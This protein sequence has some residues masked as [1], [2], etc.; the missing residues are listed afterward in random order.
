LY[1]NNVIQVNSADGNLIGEAGEGI[2]TI[3]NNILL[4]NQ[5]SEAIVLEYEKELTIKNNIISGFLWR[6]IRDK[7]PHNDTTIIH[8]NLFLGVN[9]QTSVLMYQGKTVSFKNNVI[10]YNGV[11]VSAIWDTLETDYN[12]YWQ[13]TMDVKDRAKKGPHD[14]NVD[15][16]FVKD[17]PPHLDSTYDFHLQAFSPGI[18]A[19]DPNILDVDGSRSDIGLF[20]GPGGESYTYQDLAPRDPRNLSAVVDSNY[21]TLR[22]NRNTEAD[23]S[24]YKVYRDTVISFQIDTTKL[25]SSQTDTFFVQINPHNV[26]KY[27]YKITCV[28]N[29]GNESPPSTELV[30]NITSVS[31]EDYPMTINDYVLYQN[32]PNPFNPSTKIGYKLKERGYVKVMVYDVKGELVSVLVNKEQNAGYYE[33][34]FSVGSP[35]SSVGNSIASGIYLYRIEVIGEGRIPVFSDMKKMMLVK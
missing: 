22:W 23:T 12:I 28:D 32:Y 5:N 1:H 4:S 17:V 30:V 26:S 20:G 10:A 8:N 3:T 6:G 14:I 35:Q 13:N 18:D 11:G 25:I 2:H 16:M 29:Q 19:G 24:Y 15:P 33:V 9:P 31:N 7:G 21:I 27:V 34:E